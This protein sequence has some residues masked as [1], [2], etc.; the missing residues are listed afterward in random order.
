MGEFHFLANI[1][2][3]FLHHGIANHHGTFKLS[4]DILCSYII[5]KNKMGFGWFSGLPYVDFKHR[6]K[7]F[8]L[9]FSWFG[10]SLEL[11]NR[12]L[13]SACCSVIDIYWPQ[14]QDCCEFGQNK[15]TSQVVRVQ[16]KEFPKIS[17]SYTFFYIKTC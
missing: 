1:P 10:C 3:Y 15:V 6:V 2:L 17:I 13:L 16:R 5:Y 14:I 8:T 7:N 11:W 12:H 4:C 9:C